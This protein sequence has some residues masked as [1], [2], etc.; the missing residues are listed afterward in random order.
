MKGNINRIPLYASNE[1]VARLSR[2][3]TK[4]GW[5][6]HVAW[7]DDQA[8][9]LDEGMGVCERSVAD[10]ASTQAACFASD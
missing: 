8:R 6:S 2:A 3:K 10:M 9:I 7:S 1:L 5:V 4:A